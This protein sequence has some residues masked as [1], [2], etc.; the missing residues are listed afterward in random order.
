ME[1]LKETIQR[2]NTYDFCVTYTEMYNRPAVII[3]RKECG[4][5][6]LG[7]MHHEISGMSVLADM[8][9]GFEDDWEAG[10][11]FAQDIL[12]RAA[13]PDPAETAR[14]REQELKD[15]VADLRLRH[16]SIEFSVSHDGFPVASLLWPS[17][18]YFLRIMNCPDGVIV[19]AST[20]NHYDDLDTAMAVVRQF[21][22]DAPDVN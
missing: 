1:K 22:A 4:G 19:A 21:I 8:E 11:K 18:E 12:D 2:L 20:F 5:I 7:I 10:A 9:Y 6:I 14:R 3:S 16:F 15:A 17:G 13:D